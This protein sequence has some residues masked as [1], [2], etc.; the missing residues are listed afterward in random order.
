MDQLI[1]SIMRCAVMRVGFAVG[2]HEV[3]GSAD[4]IIGLAVD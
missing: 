3:A 1:E 2:G 4:P